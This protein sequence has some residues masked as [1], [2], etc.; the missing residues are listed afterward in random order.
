MIQKNQKQ[1]QTWKYWLE[2]K[3][4]KN[5]NMDNYVTKLQLFKK[6]NFLIKS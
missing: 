4:K 5:V 1:L 2:R 3:N 6:I